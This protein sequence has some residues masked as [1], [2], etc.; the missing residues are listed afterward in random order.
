MGGL[1][2]S[3]SEEDRLRLALYYSSLPAEAAKGGNPALIPRGKKLYK[4][5][6]SGCHGDHG[7]GEAGYARLAGQR[8]DYVSKMLR[9]SHDRRGARYSHSMS[10]VAF[11]LSEEDREAVATYVA[12]LR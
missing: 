6:C 10:R 9:D 4:K 11:E 3:F 7:V 5:M 8:S 1:A 2:R 12:N